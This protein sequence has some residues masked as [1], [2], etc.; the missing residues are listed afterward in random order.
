MDPLPERG[1]QKGAKPPVTISE[2]TDN[3]PPSQLDDAYVALLIRVLGVLE[4]ISCAVGGI[5]YELE[6]LN[7]RLESPVYTKHG[8]QSVAEYKRMKGGGVH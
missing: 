7:Q 6:K 4:D 3:P 8:T 5:S 2:F 1:S